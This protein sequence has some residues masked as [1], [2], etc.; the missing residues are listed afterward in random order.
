MSPRTNLLLSAAVMAA[1]K[2]PA[3]GQAVDYHLE[4]MNLTGNPVMNQPTY[5]SQAPGDPS[6]VLYFSQRITTALSGFGAVNSMGGIYRSVVNGTAS[7]AQL[8]LDFS[9]RNITNDDGLQTFAFSP[10][11]NNATTSGYGK[12]YVA[13]S[14]YTGGN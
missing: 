2:L 11:F 12:I 13:N 8:V 10:D 7:T 9:S 5:L 14:E 4:R 1:A 3:Y 6:N